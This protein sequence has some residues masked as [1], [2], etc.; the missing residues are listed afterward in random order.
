MTT[1]LTK[2]RLLAA[3][4]DCRSTGGATRVRGL[5][6]LCYARNYRLGTLDQY[7][8]MRGEYEGIAEID[9]A[10]YRQLD[11]WIRQGY[12][13]VEAAGS[14]VWRTWPAEEIEVA[15]VMARLTRV[16]IPPAVAER[17]A[18]NGPDLGEGVRVVIEP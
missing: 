6:D 2:T 1:L 17:I 5:C 4:R 11:Y 13:R 9:G 16:G 12:L 14:G 3:C 15:R 10:S 18:R 7:P 8:R